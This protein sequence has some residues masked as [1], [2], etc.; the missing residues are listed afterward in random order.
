MAASE[1]GPGARF[2]GAAR[3]DGHELGFRRRS[4]RWGGGAADLLPDP[5]GVVWGAVF[6]IEAWSA[7]DAREGLGRAYE[8]VAVTVSL[9]GRDVSAETY[10]VIDREPADVPPTPDY[11]ATMLRGARE[12]GLPEE[13]ITALE[14]RFGQ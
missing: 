12:C 3:L 13:Y 10:V 1:L 5:G 14:R 4:V 11:A 6:E 7:L 9:D 2:L 8:R